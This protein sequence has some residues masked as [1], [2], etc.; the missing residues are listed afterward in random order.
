MYEFF[1]H[2]ADVGIRVRSD[3]LAG[4]V[5]EGG[6]AVFALLVA[7][8]ETIRPA[9]SWHARVGGT[10]PEDLLFDCLA[11]WLSLFTVDRLL[12]ARFEAR[13][14]ATGARLTAWGEPY[15]PAR[16]ELD[17]DVKAITYHQLRVEHDPDG[18][19]AQLIVDV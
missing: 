12:L 10:E 17:H 13:L 6:R 2:T 5:E 1:E 16:H 3:T 11:Q 8:P 4:L 7:N 9:E 19:Q 18:W 15:D 14:D